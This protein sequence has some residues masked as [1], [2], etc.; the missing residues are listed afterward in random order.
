MLNEE[1][2]VYVIN[3]C[4]LS[5]FYYYLLI[6]SKTECSKVIIDRISSLEDYDYFELLD[7]FNKN[8]VIPNRLLNKSL[9]NKICSIY[10]VKN[11]RNLINEL[12]RNNDISDI[13]SLRRKYY[14]Y[15]LE[16]CFSIYGNILSDIKKG[17]AV[18]I[19]LGRYLNSFGGYDSILSN[20]TV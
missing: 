16:K 12:S 20:P 1:S 3:N 14:D 11:Y 8:M 17:V 5:E 6:S 9:I 2:Q 10:S 7:I 19:A 15:F 13:E 18:D 4:D